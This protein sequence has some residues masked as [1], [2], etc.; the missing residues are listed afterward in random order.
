[1]CRWITVLAAEDMSLSDVVLAPPNSL[2]QL[3]KD[4]SFHPGYTDENNHTTNGDGFGIGWYHSNIVTVPRYPSLTNDEVDGHDNLYAAVFKDSVP[5]WN[6]MNL[7]EICVAT[8]SKCILAHVRDASRF[9]PV[10]QEKYHPF[11]CGRLLF[12]H[13]GRIHHFPKIRRA[14]LA[15]LTD[16]AFHFVKGTTDS[17]CLFA[18]ILTFLEEDGKAKVPGMPPKEQDAPFGHARLVQAIKKTYKYVEKL[19]Q[20]AILEG[21]VQDYTFST[22]NFALADGES[23]VVTRFCDRSPTVLPPSLYYAYGTCVF[24]F[25]VNTTTG[26][27]LLS[28]VL[29]FLAVVFPP[30]SD[31]QDFPFAVNR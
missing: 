23:L 2:V 18:L 3:S 19:I 25:G 29:C 31:A 8:R 5:A 10:T 28:A 15:R 17:E 20:D 26:C 9:A 24:S 16:E 12:C 14:I 7:R 6:N 30:Q 22:M 11:K 27:S 4:A 1:M 13:N 21:K